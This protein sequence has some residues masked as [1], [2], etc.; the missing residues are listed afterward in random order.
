[1]TGQLPPAHELCHQIKSFFLSRRNPFIQVFQKP[2][3]REDATKLVLEKH[4][5]FLCLLGTMW[6]DYCFAL[7]MVFDQHPELN[8]VDQFAIWLNMR[9]GWGG[10][11][12]WRGVEGV[13]EEGKWL[14]QH[15]PSPPTGTQSHPLPGISCKNHQRLPGRT[16]PNLCRVPEE[17][18]H[19]RSH[20]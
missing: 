16:T 6:C 12:G 14:G 2:F 11:G 7:L 19:A 5:L 8:S 1:M 15:Y 13:G 10:W 4:H 20:K 17:Y 18:T 9:G 3:H